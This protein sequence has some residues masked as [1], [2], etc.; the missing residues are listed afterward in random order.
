MSWHLGGTRPIID[1]NGVSPWRKPHTI[2]AACS[3]ISITR[4]YGT[5]FLSERCRVLASSALNSL[6]DQ[7]PGVG[8]GAREGV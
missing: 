6:L 1:A 7:W 2:N 8:I 5:D 3:I 4:E